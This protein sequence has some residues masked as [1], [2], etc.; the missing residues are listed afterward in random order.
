MKKKRKKK[1][2]SIYSGQQYIPYTPGMI[3]FRAQ[4]AQA[5]L[6]FTC[7][8]TE[9]LPPSAIVHSHYISAATKIQEFHP[10]KHFCN[11]NIGKP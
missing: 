5:F 7:V 2:Y 1:Y 4:K 8:R 9:E 11:T 3:R 6:L 10:W